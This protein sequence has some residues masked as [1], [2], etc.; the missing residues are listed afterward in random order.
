MEVKNISNSEK[1]PFNI[2]GWS[3]IKKDKAELIY[4]KLSPGQV[5]EIHKNPFDVMFFVVS[6]KGTLLHEEKEISMNKDDS[7]FIDSSINRGWKNNSENDLI[8]LVYKILN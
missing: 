8:L 4:L 2:D 1:V 7:I 3:L 6:G 5:L